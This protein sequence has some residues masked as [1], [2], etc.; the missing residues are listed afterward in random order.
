MDTD[1]PQTSLP[2]SFRDPSGFMFLR[3]ATLF[4]Q[5]NQ[6]A[7]D[8]YNELNNSGL[9]KELV[10][11]GLLVSHVETDEPAYNPEHAFKIIQPELIPFISYP[12]EWS[13]SQ[14]KDAAL[15]TLE[16]Q[17]ISI[18][19][20][21]TL[22][23]AS[24][25]NI[26]FIG[27]RPIFIDTLSFSCHT[28]DQPWIAYRQFCRHFLAPLSLM[29]YR[30]I[31]LNRLLSIHMDGIPL[32]LTSTLLPFKT[33]LNIGLFLHIHCHARSEKHYANITEPNKLKTTR[34]VSRNAQ[35]GIIDNL[36]ATIQRLQ[37]PEKKLE[38]TEYYS[39]TNYETEAFKQKQIFIETNISSIRPQNGMGFRCQ[40]RRIQCVSCR[41]LG[42]CTRYGFGSNMCRKQLSADQTQR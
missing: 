1:D 16:I 26:Q 25:F 22:K 18:E 3:R 34:A 35:L 13:F 37:S 11:K 6:C 9:Y 32:Q 27:C 24:G 42:V 19:H 15:L 10:K 41:V 30:D 4:R 21:M 20:G 7:K 14:L 28:E 39:N 38:W 23:D 31:T 33:R 40:C 8:D 12:Y 36:I 2:A 17:K 29:R 5:I